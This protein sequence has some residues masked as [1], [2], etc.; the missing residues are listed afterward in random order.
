MQYSPGQTALPPAPERCHWGVTLLWL[1][2]VLC[3]LG[4][5]V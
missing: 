1:T 5:V 3:L 2:P 4:T